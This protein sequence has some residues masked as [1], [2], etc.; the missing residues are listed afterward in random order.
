MDAAHQVFQLKSMFQ[1]KSNLANA[2]IIP[3]G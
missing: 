1:P 3:E 2:E